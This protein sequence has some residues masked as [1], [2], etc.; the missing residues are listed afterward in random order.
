MK[1]MVPTAPEAA[2]KPI[3]LQRR[4]NELEVRIAALQTENTNLRQICANPF[5][6]SPQPES[7][8]KQLL[9]IC[10]NASDMSHLLREIILFFQRFTGCEA[11]GV[12]LRKGEDFPYYE[13]RGF[14]RAFVEAENS[15]C[16][17]DA[18]GRL[19][20][21][22]D[23]N[24][25]LRCM[26]GKVLYGRFDRAQL[27]FSS[28]GSF[29]TNDT[30]ALSVSAGEA[31]RVICRR[32]NQAGYESVALV[33]LR[34]QGRIF[35]LLQFNDSWRDRFS[36]Q[37]IA[38]LEELAGYAALAL[39]KLLADEERQQSEEK[40]RL[41]VENSLAPIIVSQDGRLVMA[42]QAAERIS[43]YS[44]DQLLSGSFG[45]FI[46][47]EDAEM[48]F[49][50]HYQRLNFED[51]SQCYI[52]RVI[53]R[54]GTL[55]WVEQYGTTISWRGR[56]AALGFLA[57]ITERVKAEEALKAS[58]TE[59]KVLLREVHHR[60]KNNLAAVIGLLELQ[61][62]TLDGLGEQRT[63]LSDL[64]N[65]I[66]SMSLVHEKLY[67]SE[68]LSKIDFQDYARDLISH[69]RTSFGTRHIQ[70][71][72][73]VQGVTVP[74]DLA[75][76]CGMILNEIVTN[77]LKHAFPQAKPRT[78]EEACRIRVVMRQ[79]GSGYTLE[80]SDNGVGL[81]AGFEWRCSK[82]LGLVL[83]RMLGEHQLC[84]RYEMFSDS[85]TRFKLTFSIH[86]ERKPI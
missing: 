66:R 81:P 74:L 4:I 76:P 8:Q 68:S 21:N 58:L 78:G 50:K 69:L 44:A 46:H 79:T 45:Q 6:A 28:G 14:S 16:R 18:S 10:H 57:D 72:I 38:L 82:S 15:L 55:R 71:D 80:V 48:V 25:V 19:L 62:R 17:T 3:D 51:V 30:T 60:V 24:P 65:R 33:P 23:G 54:D 31:G 40:Y 12:R 73:D 70:C 47:P 13:T 85:G 2:F 27:F 84:G 43:G 22:V 56:P 32:C 36:E 37:K 75:V 53:C 34:T 86:R 61:C 64:S 29:W 83:V 1:N 59:K 9:R 35:G 5:Q 67:R 20:C 77:A 63:V 49:N 41:I 39:A 11:A 52:F 26:C 42:N 7:A